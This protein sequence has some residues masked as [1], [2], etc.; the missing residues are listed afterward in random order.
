MRVGFL[1]TYHLYRF[2]GF[3]V[4]ESISVP[5][6]VREIAKLTGNDVFVTFDIA[7]FRIR[8]LGSSS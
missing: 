4:R 2:Q 6:A 1:R 5:F 7:F 8:V 3:V